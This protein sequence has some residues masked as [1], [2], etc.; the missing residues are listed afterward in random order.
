MIVYVESNFVLE[1]AFLR[2]E[3][4]SCE[5]ILALSESREIKLALPAFSI[6]EPYEAWVRRYKQR[7]ELHNRLSQEIRELSRSVPYEESSKELQEVTNVLV[8]SGEEEKQR[9]DDTI[10]TILQ[11]AEVIPIGLEIIK[12]AI[13]FQKTQNLSPQDSIVYASVLGHLANAADEPKCFLTKNSKDFANPDIYGELNAYGCKLLTRFK[14][15]LGYIQSQ[16]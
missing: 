2:E 1:L 5:S 16:P 7:A 10:S 11:I 13:Q 3:H 12:A 15:G 6:G 8:K 9:L 14:D 4:S